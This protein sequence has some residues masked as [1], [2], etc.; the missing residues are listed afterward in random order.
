M[1][2]TQARA[3]FAELAKRPAVVTIDLH[4]GHL[5]P[6]TATLPLPADAA[7]A[8]VERAVPLLDEYRGLGLPVIH[9]V[10]AYRDRD[11][12]LSNAY[13]RFQAGRPDSPRKQIAEHNLIGMPGLELMPDIERPGDTIVETKKRYDCFVGTDLGFRLQ[14]GGHDSVLMLGVNTNSCVIATSI[15]ASVRDYAVFVVDEG[16]DTM[17]PALHDAALAIIDASFGWVISAQTTLEILRD[18]VTSAVPE[19][20][21]A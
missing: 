10:T 20:A 1:E 16:V 4:R 8:L 5:D 6:E 14:T 17:L 11:E 19:P 13:W 7:L 15:A 18:R 21:R 3:S 12:I 9:V 2:S